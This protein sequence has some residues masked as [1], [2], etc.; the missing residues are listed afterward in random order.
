MRYL[1]VALAMIVGITVSACRGSATNTEQGT[2]RTA[3]YAVIL[4]NDFTGNSLRVTGDRSVATDAEYP[5]LDAV[6]ICVS[7]NADGTSQGAIHDLCPSD[8]TPEG[9][10]SFGFRMYANADCTGDEMANIECNPVTGEYLPWGETTVNAVVCETHNA[11]KSFDV[12]VYDPATGAGSDC[13]PLDGTTPIRT[14]TDGDGIRD[15]WDPDIDGDGF[16]NA[17]DEC[18]LVVGVAPDGCPVLFAEF[19]YN[20]QLPTSSATVGNV[21]MTF[22]ITIGSA[23]TL[24]KIGIISP[25]AGVRAQL[26]VYA[27]RTTVYGD[28]PGAFVA[29][30]GL[31]TLV[32]G[33]NELPVTGA[34]PAVTTGT[35]WLAVLYETNT[36]AYLGGPTAYEWNI[37]VAFGTAL[38]ANFPD[39]PP[40]GPASRNWMQARN[41]YVVIGL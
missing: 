34:P 15:E 7:L 25:G 9:T 36:L 31:E 23:G 1:H 5:C 13:L 27:N 18:D 37:G 39:A 10:W 4:G 28:S 19:G 20:T 6:D 30:S 22:P 8:D 11:D 32:S 14:D 40:T 33:E 38:P 3:S 21:L 35:Y 12:C 2:P 29:A 17:V 41:L 26:A 16:L 24:E